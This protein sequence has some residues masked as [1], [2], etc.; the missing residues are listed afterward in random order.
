M[1]E[2]VLVIDDNAT[3]LKLTRIILEHAGYAVETAPSADEALALLERTAPRVILTDVQ[4]PG[5][6]GLELT[7][8][9]KARSPEI[10][11]IVLTAAVTRRDED[12]ARSAGCDDYVTK[13]ID[14]PRLLAAVARYA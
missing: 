2:P 6:S 12:E 1:P 4:L 9:V 14:I 10:A 11:V 8:I 3:N 5:M 13:P 7:R